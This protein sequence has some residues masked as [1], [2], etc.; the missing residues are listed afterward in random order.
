MAFQGGSTVKDLIDYLVSSDDHFKATLG[1]VTGE[2]AV[3]SRALIIHND[4]ITRTDHFANRAADTG[5]FINTANH[6]IVSLLRPRL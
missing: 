6:G 3:R 5:S 2:E 1:E 4:H